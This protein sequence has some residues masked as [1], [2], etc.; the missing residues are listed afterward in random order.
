MQ[1]AFKLK[2]EPK[3]MPWVT[4]VE[5]ITLATGAIDQ[6]TVDETLFFQKLWVYPGKAVVAGVITA[7]GADIRVGKSGTAATQYLP[8]VLAAGDLPLK[9]ELPLGQK[10]KL[11]QILIKGTAGDGVFYSYT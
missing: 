4:P 9:I 11:S 5:G 2:N 8:D 6:L 3:A 7:N 1:G 10:M